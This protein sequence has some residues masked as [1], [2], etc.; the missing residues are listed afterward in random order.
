MTW[1]QWKAACQVVAEEKIGAPIRAQQRA[2]EA[3]VEA[4]KDRIRAHMPKVNGV[5]QPRFVAPRTITDEIVG[6]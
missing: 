4:T 6:A 1:Q 3:E 2:E 5:A